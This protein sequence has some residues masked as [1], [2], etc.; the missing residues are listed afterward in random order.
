MNEA[1][2]SLLETPKPLRGSDG[3]S[4]VGAGDTAGSGTGG[5]ISSGRG[6]GSSN[7][8]VSLGTGIGTGNGSHSTLTGVD[9]AGADGGNGNDAGTGNSTGVRYHT[10][11]H[12]YWQ[13][14]YQKCCLVRQ[15]KDMKQARQHLPLTSNI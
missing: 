6:S 3:T 10:P 15:A 7:S 12:H 1:T 5:S 14:E 13:R 9:G 4:L 11:G 8:H 2:M